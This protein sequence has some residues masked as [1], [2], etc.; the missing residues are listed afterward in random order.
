MA[1]PVGVVDVFGYGLYLAQV[2]RRHESRRVL[3][4]FGDASVVEI[5]ESRAGNTFRAMYTV[6]FAA[7][8]FVLHVFQKK[9]QQ[10]IATPKRDM[11]LIAK[12]QVNLTIVAQV[13]NSHGHAPVLRPVATAA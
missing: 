11:D 5:I 7:A 2:G 3:R 9:A 12:P 1:M 4:G 8:V 13:S 10:G 6:R